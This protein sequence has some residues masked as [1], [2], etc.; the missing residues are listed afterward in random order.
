[1]T[2]TGPMPE[3][4][5]TFQ[6]GTLTQRVCRNCGNQNVYVELWESSDGAYEDEKFT[7]KTCGHVYWIDGIDS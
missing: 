4:A 1:M 5:G 6:E 3:S 2:H 7:C